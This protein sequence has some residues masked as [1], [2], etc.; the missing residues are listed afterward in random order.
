MSLGSTIEWTDATWNPVTGCTKI[1]SGCK[2]C[3]AERMAY[4]LQSMGQPRYQNGFKLTLHPD[5]LD[6]PLMW[7]KSRMIFVNSMSDLFHGKVSFSFIENAFNIIH[8]ANWHIFQILTKRA[9]RL[10]KF[11]RRISL[12]PNVWI[13]VTV[14][15]QDYT[16]RIK[17]LQQVPASV[18]F[19]SLEPLLGPI[20][21]L[22]LEGID[23][24]IVGGESGPR[25]R[26]LEAKWVRDIR[27]QCLHESVPFFFKQW[28]GFHKSRNGR[29]LDGRTWDELPFLSASEIE[30]QAYTINRCL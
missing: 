13:G 27:N 22:P 5:L 14:E 12:P 16:Y 29:N 1:S 8:D 2:N 9:N 20:D 25:A 19:I 30:G 23:W 21:N 7:K 6:Q 18:R 26:I 17:S 3:Y 10:A 11:S 24:V 15:N 4:R 28:G